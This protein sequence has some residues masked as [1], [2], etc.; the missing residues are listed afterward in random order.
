MQIV[1]LL[2]FI[3]II[4]AGRYTNTTFVKRTVPGLMVRRIN[5]RAVAQERQQQR[6]LVPVLA[7]VQEFAQQKQETD[8]TPIRF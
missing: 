2:V 4:H 8:Q 7:T 6:M 1:T 5:F 3:I